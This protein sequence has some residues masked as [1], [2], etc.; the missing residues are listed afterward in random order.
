MRREWETRSNA[1]KGAFS[2]VRKL[3][4]QIRVRRTEKE[5]C[6]SGLYIEYDLSYHEKGSGKEKILCGR[7]QR[8]KASWLCIL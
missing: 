4:Y 5:P 3:H 7:G 6:D 2:V 8:R 1:I